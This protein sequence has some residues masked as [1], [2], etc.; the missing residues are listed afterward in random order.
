[1]VIPCVLILGQISPSVAASPSVFVVLVI[2][3]QTPRTVL[4]VVVPVRI[5]VMYR[6]DG[7]RR[8]LLLM[9]LKRTACWSTLTDSVRRKKVLIGTATYSC[10]QLAESHKGAPQQVVWLPKDERVGRQRLSKRISHS[11]VGETGLTSHAEKHSSALVGRRG[12]LHKQY[13]KPSLQ[14]VCSKGLS[15]RVQE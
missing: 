13:I 6:N 4:T 15:L 9:S 3:R 5:A 11:G 12:W 7:R 10:M 8:L 2:V 1:M 14:R